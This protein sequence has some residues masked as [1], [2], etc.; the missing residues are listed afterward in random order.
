MIRHEKIKNE[1]RGK[2]K[3]LRERDKFNGKYEVPHET[4]T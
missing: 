1:K 2:K 3:K 4:K